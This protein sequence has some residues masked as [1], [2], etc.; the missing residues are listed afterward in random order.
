MTPNTDGSGMEVDF[1]PIKT[2]ISEKLLRDIEQLKGMLAPE[3]VRNFL[4][5]NRLLSEI[6]AGIRSYDVLDGKTNLFGQVFAA[7][8][9]IE[10]KVADTGAQA[11][12]AIEKE[13]GLPKASENDLGGNAPAE[14]A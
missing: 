10:R 5:Q 4:E 6:Q 11:L 3:N 8:K 2:H 14:N 12:S 13:L 7:A 9:P 1:S